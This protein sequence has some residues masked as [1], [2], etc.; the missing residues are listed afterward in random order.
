[1]ARGGPLRAVPRRAPRGG[2]TRPGMPYLAGLRPMASVYWSV[3][4]W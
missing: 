2:G 3:R 4:A 1:M